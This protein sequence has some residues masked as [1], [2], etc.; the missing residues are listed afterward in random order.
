MLEKP[1]NLEPLNIEEPRR[2]MGDEH[3]R[4]RRNSRVARTLFWLLPLI[5]VGVLAVYAHIRVTATGEEYRGLWAPFARVFDLLLNLAL[6]AVVCAT[7]RMVSRK[8]R[9]AFTSFAEEVAFSI[10]LGTGAVGLL[11]FALGVFGLFQMVPMSVL[12]LSLLALARR[13]VVAIGNG[14]VEGVRRNLLSK[15]RRIVGALFC[16]V[17]V[18]LTARALLPPYAVDDAICHLAVPKEFIEA[19]GIRPLYDNFPSNM[20]LLAHMLYVVCLLA[21]SD[22]AAR[23]FSLSLA[24]TTACSLYAFGARFLTRKVGALALFAFFGAGL[25]NEVAITN[26]IDVTVAGMLFLAASAMMSYLETDGRGWLWASALLSGF[27]LSIKYTAGVWIALMGVMFLYESLMRKRQSILTVLK[28]GTLFAVIVFAVLSPWLVKNYVY[29]KNPMYPF[30]TGEVADYGARGIRYFTPADEQKMD[31]YFAQSRRE[32]PD[33]VELIEKNLA[34]KSSQKK[35]R[36]PLRFWEY[37]TEPELYMMGEAE[38]H[39]DPN[40]LFFAIPMLFLLPPKRWL[41]WLGIFCAAFFV[42]VA[43]SSWLVRYQMP[44]YPA[45]TILAAYTLVTLS[46]KMSR[47]V[48]FARLLPVVVVALVLSSSLFV[49]ATQLHKTGGWGFLRGELSRREFLQAAYYY[50]ALD[51]LNYNTPEDAKVMLLGVQTGYHLRRDH[52]P[53]PAWDSVEWQRLLVR[54]D[55]LEEMRDDLK[56]R[57][58]SYIVFNPGLYKYIAMVGRRGSGP[59]GSVY[60]SPSAAGVGPDYRVQLRNWATFELFSSRHLDFV[61]EAS[62]NWVFKL[63]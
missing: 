27:S 35:E 56:R 36:H 22:I 50:P 49:F 61:H 29:F 60:S 48:T 15:E 52:I 30:V 16:A 4:A 24:V 47:R 59:A 62:G 2:T 28:R 20:P 40:T 38:A 63:K 53:D 18:I 11:V 23:L 13:D 14:M 46:E 8:L 21:E 6:V 34:F 10:M 9:L 58:V 42:F 54:N 43:S 41:V 45:L 12:M 25:V 39:H 7:G 44:I 32:I 1:I 31:A 33:T 37:Y 55:S 3:T 19:G 17:L 51:Y 26:R 57:G 5:C